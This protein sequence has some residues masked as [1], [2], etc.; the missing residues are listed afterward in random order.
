M[1]HHKKL[2]AV[3]FMVSVEINAGTVFNLR[4]YF[5]VKAKVYGL[6]NFNGFITGFNTDQFIK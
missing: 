1:L 5:F 4:N 3:T 6:I 2:D